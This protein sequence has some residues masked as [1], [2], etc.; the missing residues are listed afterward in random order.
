MH[1]KSSK[2]ELGIFIR[3]SIPVVS[4]RDIAER[5]RKEHKTILRAIDNLECSEEFTQHNFVPC[6]YKNQKNVTQREYLVTKDGFAFL[7]MGFTGKEA[8]VFKEKYIAAFNYM[9]DSLN[10]RHDM[11]ISFRPM[12]EAIREAHEEPKPHH[13]T[14]EINMIYRI[15]LGMDAKHYKEKMGL[16]GDANLRDHITN[17]QK[18]MVD[19]LQITDT[20]L[21]NVGIEYKERKELLTNFFLKSKTKLQN[22]SLLC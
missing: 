22:E 6:T 12:T 5:F 4:S 1:T 7:V 11:R 15:I 14:N 9:A 16:T 17:E 2:N 21:L 8:A 13:Y 19:Q 20:G 18:K 10:Y 3:N